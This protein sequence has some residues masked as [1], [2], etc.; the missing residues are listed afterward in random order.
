MKKSALIIAILAFV[1]AFSCNKKKDAPDKDSR[2]NYIGNY[3]CLLRSQQQFYDS[4]NHPYIHDTSYFTNVEVKK[5]TNKDGLIING[6][7]VTLSDE[8]H[9]D[10]PR[11]TGNF[12]ANDSLYIDNSHWDGITYSNI[13]RGK[14][15]NH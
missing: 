2:E 10:A 4:Q 9:F 11:F 14:K 1:V 3:A 7:E 12:F 5:S 8:T 13:Y 15:I 6:L